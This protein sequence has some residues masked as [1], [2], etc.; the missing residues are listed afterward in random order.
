MTQNGQ[1]TVTE[2]RQKE[3]DTEQLPRNDSAQQAEIVALT[4]ACE[5]RK[6][7]KLTIYTDS[8]VQQT[9]THCKI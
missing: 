1:I 8:N 9:C 6:E 4:S 7:R 5:M 2:W 3:T